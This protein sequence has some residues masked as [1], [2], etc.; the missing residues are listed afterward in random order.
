MSEEW[1]EV[2]EVV[3]GTVKSVRDYG[4]YITLDEYEGK[5]GFLHISEVST[6]WVRSIRDYVRE[7]RKVVVK[8]IGVDPEKRHIDL[9]LRRVTETERREALKLWRRGRS[10]ARLLAQACKEAGMK[11]EEVLAK[12]RDTIEEAFEDLYG[13]FEAALEG[14]DEAIRKTGMPESLI[15]AV[16]KVAREKVTVRK[17]EVSGVCEIYFY[18]PDGVDRIKEAVRYALKVSR[19]ESVEDVKFYTLGSPRYR[20]EVIGKDYSST[21]RFLRRVIRRLEAKVMDLGGVFRYTEGD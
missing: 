15:Q 18:D 20:V 14:E 8:V 21:A 1:P 9:S 4:A 19:P 6:T 16:K 7:G 12:Y 5:V 17:A 13:L 11:Y 3:I 10:G 2:G